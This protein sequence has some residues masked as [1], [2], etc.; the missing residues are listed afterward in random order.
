MTRASRD[1]GFTLIEV[2]VAMLILSIAVAGTMRIVTDA[3]VRAAGEAQRLEAWNELRYR[4]RLAQAASGGVSLEQ[5]QALAEWTVTRDIVE[6]GDLAG[7]AVAWVTVRGEIRWRWRGED[8]F[9]EH[10]EIRMIAASRS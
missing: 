3:N 2:L 8:R 4:V 6:R 5:G 10:E 1:R 9:L 7:V